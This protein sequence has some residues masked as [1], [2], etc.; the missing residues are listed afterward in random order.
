MKIVLCEDGVCDPPKCPV[1]DVQENQVTIGEKDNVCTLT[2]GQFDILKEKMDTRINWKISKF[3]LFFPR[4]NLYI[5]FY[6]C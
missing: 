1:V 6:V 2:R 3:Y 4:F 5:F